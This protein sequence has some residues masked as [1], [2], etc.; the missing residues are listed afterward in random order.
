MRHVMARYKTELCKKPP[1]MCRQGYSCP[2]YHNGKDKRRMPDRWHYRSTPCPAVRPGEEWLDSSQCEIGDACTYCHTRTEQQFHPEI[3]KSTKCNDVLNSGYCPRGPFCAFAHDDTE[4]AIGRDY[5]ANFQHFPLSP[6]STATAT[7][8][9]V[10]PTS[11]A[12]SGQQFLQLR[13]HRTASGGAGH[14]LD[15]FSPG[16]SSA[17][18]SPN[19]SPSSSG[20]VGVGNPAIRGLHWPPCSTPILP[21]GLAPHQS[22]YSVE[23]V[24]A[25]RGRESSILDDTC[26]W[27]LSETLT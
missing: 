26:S 10:A 22:A 18:F 12:L 7:G 21:G 19:S 3:Y 27:R 23:L 1:R 6:Q 2:Y 4:M 11:A 20:H 24:A 15:L 9:I 16:G 13:G 8:A 25:P 14:D 17:I 5:L